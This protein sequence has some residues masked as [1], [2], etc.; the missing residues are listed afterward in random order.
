MFC[1]LTEAKLRGLLSLLFRQ[2]TTLYT[3][4]SIELVVEFSFNARS[5]RG[6]VGPG[7]T[8]WGK[9]DSGRLS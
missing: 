9:T 1:V 2:V 6:S 5:E 4:F 8:R 7:T 3:S